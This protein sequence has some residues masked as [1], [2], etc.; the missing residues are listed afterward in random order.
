MH[1]SKLH[2]ITF[3]LITVFILAVLAG[4]VSATSSQPVQEQGG[5]K[6]IA[7]GAYD[8]AD[9][10]IVMAKDE[11]QKK[12][13]FYNLQKKKNYTLNYDGITK[14][15]DKYGSQISVSQLQEGEVVDVQFLKGEKLLT[16]LAASSAIWTMDNVSKFELDLN[17]GKIKIR[18][19]EY[20]LDEIT[21][22][23]SGGKK[24]DF[25]NI[26]NQDILQIKG[27][28]RQIYSITIE[29]GHGYLR[30]ENEEYFIGGWIEIGQKIIHQIQDDMTFVV[31]EGVYDVYLSNTAIEGTKKIEI[32]RNKET[33]LDVG[34]LRKEELVKYGNLN[35]TVFPSG[36]NVYIDGNQ[37]DISKVIRA[38]YGLHQIMVKAD[39]YDSVTQYVRVNED[40]AKVS[41]SL[42]KEAVRSVSNNSVN[43]KPYTNSSTISGNSVIKQDKNVSDNSLESY[44]IPMDGSKYVT[45]ENPYLEDGSDS[46]SANR[47]TG[48]YLIYV[49]EPA[50][51][52]LYVDDRYMGVI[53]VSFEKQPG[54][55]KMELRKPGFTSKSYTVDVDEEKKDISYSFLQLTPV[56]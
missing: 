18:N 36:A 26:S 32:T 4:C 35:I 14:F 50:G 24:A 33:L 56:K 39:G 15:M 19:E 54:S 48:E 20:I 16:S 1:K 21:T 25:T 42:E 44:S 46:T 11:D 5:F 13:T 40:G 9:T 30:L 29:T 17:G 3:L 6:K 23:F 51:A 41:V 34:D 47:N 53:P 38:S 8:S 37:V 7:P 43:T 2:K 31:P 55:H 10:A 27:I 52:D 45:S 12:I 49:I 22:V 28:E